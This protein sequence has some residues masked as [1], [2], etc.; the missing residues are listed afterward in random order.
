MA[1]PSPQPLWSHTAIVALMRKVLAHNTLH[2]GSSHTKL[3][4]RLRHRGWSKSR[5]FSTVSKGEPSYSRSSR[6]DGISFLKHNIWSPPSSS[7]D[8]LDFPPAAYMIHTTPPDETPL[9]HLPHAT[10]PATKSNAQ[11]HIINHCGPLFLEQDH[12][13]KLLL[14]PVISAPSTP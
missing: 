4:A 14:I 1:I 5:F 7:S 3:D 11:S 8:R 2:T 9:I 10:Q 6:Q 13:L 12:I